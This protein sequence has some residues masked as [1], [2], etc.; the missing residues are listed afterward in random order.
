MFFDGP[1]QVDLHAN[2]KRPA[3]GWRPLDGPGRVV[4]Y[5]QRRLPAAWA[6]G[7]QVWENRRGRRRGS[8]CNGEGG[9]LSHTGRKPGRVCVL[10]QLASKAQRVRPVRVHDVYFGSVVSLRLENDLRTVRRPAWTSVPRGVGRKTGLIGAIGVHHM[11]VRA[12]VPV[13]RER[14]PGAVR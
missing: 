7:N 5:D 12:A 3:A 6:D 11:D 13:G 9:C 1:V 14:D 2:V 10:A 8:R 4:G